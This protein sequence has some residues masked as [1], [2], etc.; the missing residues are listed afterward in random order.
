MND[1]YFSTLFQVLSSE[2]QILQRTDQKAF[3]MLSILG[4]F[5][6][7]FIVHFLKVQMNWFI[8]VM[9]IVYF[10]AA[11]IAMIN[12]VLV[13]VPR[14]R[15]EKTSNG[16]QFL[17]PTFFAGISKFASP[18]EYAQYLKKTSGDEDEVYQMFAAQIFSLG[19]INK[20]KNDAIK[21]SILFFITAIVSELLIIM[22]MA[23]GRALPY[24]FPAQ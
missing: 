15:K 3:T 7:F 20:Y 23:W 14:I 2:Q 4:V 18:E 19:N 5:M 6:V 24:L 11:L 17:N 9:V 13:I 8:F 1:N 21:R 10:I 16:E 22:S 12:L